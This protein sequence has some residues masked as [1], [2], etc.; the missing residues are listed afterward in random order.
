MIKVNPQKS[1]DWITSLDFNNYADLWAVFLEYN[2]SLYLS[3]NS[4]KSSN[5]FWL[6]EIDL[7]SGD[8]IKSKW[9][10]VLNNYAIKTFIF[11]V[12][13]VSENFLFTLQDS[14]I[15]KST[16]ASINYKTSN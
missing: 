15:I 8:A 16:T 3:T 5:Y 9:F 1:V 6:T 10:K 13:M 7:V 2:S 12:V 14:M 11:N 4:A